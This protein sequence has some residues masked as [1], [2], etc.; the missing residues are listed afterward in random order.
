MAHLLFTIYYALPICSI[1]LYILLQSLGFQNNFF[2][3]LRLEFRVL[4]FKTIIL[5][6]KYMLYISEDTYKF[7]LKRII[8]L[9]Q[10][11][12]LIVI[13]INTNNKV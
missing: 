7:H 9:G 1:H 13:S 4:R 5:F 2:R 6:K 11:S 8:F 12:Y 3:N 10:V